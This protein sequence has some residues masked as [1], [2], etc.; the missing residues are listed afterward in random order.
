MTHTQRTDLLVR[1]QWFNAVDYVRDS[2][3]ET[4]YGAEQYLYVLFDHRHSLPKALKMKCLLLNGFD[5]LIHLLKLIEIVLTHRSHPF[6]HLRSLKRFDFNVYLGNSPGA[7][8]SS[9]NLRLV[10]TFNLCPSFFVR[11]PSC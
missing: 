3:F 1:C 8:V 9:T 11:S 4:V 6:A 2:E 7:T 5:P 10:R